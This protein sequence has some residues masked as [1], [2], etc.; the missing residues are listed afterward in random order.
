M[1]KIRL[2]TFYEASN[3]WDITEADL[4]REIDEQLEEYVVSNI[5]N[6]T[7]PGFEIEDFE[8]P[9]SLDRQ[10]VLDICNGKSFGIWS[11]N[12]VDF[13]SEYYQNWIYYKNKKNVWTKFGE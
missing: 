2:V 1:T 6:I 11:C 5:N 12:Y 3:C 8:V 9:D 7:A 13:N 4:D 10:L